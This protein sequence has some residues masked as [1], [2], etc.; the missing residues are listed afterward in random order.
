LQFVTIENL[1]FE[2]MVLKYD[3]EGTLFY[4]DPP[5]YEYEKYYKG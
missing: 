5:Y 4:L 3:G 2:E 1:S